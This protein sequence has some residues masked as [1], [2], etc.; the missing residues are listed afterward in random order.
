MK[1]CLLSTSCEKLSACCA[2]GIA[3]CVVPATSKM[4]DIRDTWQI[5]SLSTMKVSIQ[6]HPTW[7]WLI[8]FIPNLLINNI[9]TQIKQGTFLF[10]F[11]FTLIH[12]LVHSRFIWV[13]G[14]WIFREHQTWFLKR[15]VC[16]QTSEPTNRLRLAMCDHVSVTALRVCTWWGVKGTI[17]AQQTIRQWW[18]YVSSLNVTN[19]SP[20]HISSDWLSCFS[21]GWNS[22]WREFLLSLF[23]PFPSLFSFLDL[24]LSK[25]F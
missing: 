22:H 25:C 12:S 14:G 20:T 13:L 24:S 5:L 2:C 9:E 23:L 8:W 3:A 19:L 6:Q 18:K 1:Q 7:V 16:R 10:S 15:R 4:L 21:S 11:S 17:N